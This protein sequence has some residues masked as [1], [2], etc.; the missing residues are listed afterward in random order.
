MTLI[1]ALAGYLTA[2][3]AHHFGLRGDPLPMLALAVPI[4]ASLVVLVVTAWPTLPAYDSPEGWAAAQDGA[5][6]GLMAIGGRRVLGP[7]VRR[8]VQ[9]FVV[10][11]FGKASPAA[12]AWI[13]RMLGKGLDLLLG[14]GQGLQLL[15]AGEA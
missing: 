13:D 10:G 4:G 5:A 2:R 8:L 14:K 6:A 11:L 12:S 9:L 7:A 15:P 3:L 1:L